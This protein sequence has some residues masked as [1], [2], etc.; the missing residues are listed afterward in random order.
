MTQTTPLEDT[1][2]EALLNIREIATDQKITVSRY[3][4]LMGIVMKSLKQYEDK[5][6]DTRTSF[7]GQ[8]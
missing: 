6:H 4:L 8:H 3:V 7:I 2:Y 5:K 1:L